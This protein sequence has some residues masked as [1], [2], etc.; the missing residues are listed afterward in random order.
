MGMR[1]AAAV[2]ALTPSPYNEDI[3]L[4]V[5]A[6]QLAAQ[7]QQAEARQKLAV[8]LLGGAVLAVALGSSRS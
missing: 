8:G 4:L 3:A 7:R 2:G 5:D 1:R 6:L